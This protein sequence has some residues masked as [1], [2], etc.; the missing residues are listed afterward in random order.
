MYCNPVESA[1][2]ITGVS[3]FNSFWHHCMADCKSDI[4]CEPTDTRQTNHGSA[5]IL[6]HKVTV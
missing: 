5:K 3:S 1:I 4:K 6:L 2:S